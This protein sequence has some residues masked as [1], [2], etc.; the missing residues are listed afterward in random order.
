M[1]PTMTL[2]VATLC[3]C[4]LLLTPLVAGVAT[5]E[6]QLSCSPQEVMPGQNITCWITVCDD[7][8]EPTMD[9]AV[10]DFTVK[11]LA[12]QADVDAVI[13]PMWV[14]EDLTSAS[15]TVGTTGGTVLR[16]DVAITKTEELIRNSGYVAIVLTSPP[17]YLTNLACE[18]TTLALR[19]SVTCT[20]DA[21]GARGVPARVTVDDIFLTEDHGEGRF[22]FMDMTRQLKFTFT[23]P[24]VPSMT[25]DSF[26]IVITLTSSSSTL[27]N[28]SLKLLYPPLLATSRSLLKCSEG[29]PPTCFV[30]A[31]DDIGPVFNDPRY[32]PVA[33]EQLLN[34]GSWATYTDMV[35]QWIDGASAN[36]KRLSF[37]P[38]INNRVFP[39][40]MHVRVTSALD[41]GATAT[42]ILG[43]PVT[44]TTGVVPV[45][46]SLSIRSCSSSYITS[47]S[48]IT[49]IIDVDD[50]V[51]ADL[52][53][54]A[55]SSTKGSIGGIS[56]LNETSATNR[57]IQF[58]YTA[59]ET[60]L[61]LEDAITVVVGQD[62]I[63]RSP[64]RVVVYPR[65]TDINPRTVVDRRP[66][67]MEVG[68]TFF[69][70]VV[71]IG[72]V[73]IIRRKITKAKARTAKLRKWLEEEELREKEQAAKEEAQSAPPAPAA[74]SAPSAAQPREPEAPKAVPKELE[75][76]SQN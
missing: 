54:I 55:I 48:T 5:R 50:D 58:T 60:S 20:A 49:C 29:T 63:M 34:D 6:S 74:T 8:Q 23:A 31:A 10:S 2:S 18:S 38:R 11:V 16:I 43:S 67:K 12:E 13:Y 14:T 53:Y 59:A 19:S 21:F 30:N 3:V 39:T 17:T 44:F 36:R 35:V 37:A 66:Q 1:H 45:A 75:S 51:S 22:R 27:Y 62:D 7:T 64:W 32:F 25:Y 52:R 72:A 71:A 68:I 28:V 42:A 4:M 69:C 46:T 56:F 9:F 70:A 65:S 73:L 15:F 41:L 40:R 26:I 47:L 57:A 33:F 61:R 24:N 76:R